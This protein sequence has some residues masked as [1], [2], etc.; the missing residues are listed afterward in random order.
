MLSGATSIALTL[1]D[2]LA[3]LDEVNVCVKYRM[4]GQDGRVT[5]RFTPDAAFLAAAEPVYRSFPGIKADI[6]S[7]RSRQDLPQG[8]RDYIAFIE[9]YVGVPVSMIGVGP[10]RVQ[11]ITT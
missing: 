9:D 3:T 2:V 7:I 11:T 6:S 4:K 5:D 10:D 8:A 1:L